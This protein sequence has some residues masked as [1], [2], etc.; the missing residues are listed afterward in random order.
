MTARKDRGLAGQQGGRGKTARTGHAGDA[1]TGGARG[2]FVGHIRRGGTRRRGARQLSVLGAI[3]L[4]LT[5][6]ALL[7]VGDVVSVAQALGNESAALP[8][9]SAPEGDATTLLDAFRERET[10]LESREAAVAEREQALA[11]AAAEIEERLADLEESRESLAQMIALAD[12]AASDD[13]ARLTA[14]YENMRPQEAATLFEDMDPAFSAGFLGMMDPVAAA[15]IMG[16]L[17]PETAYS[18]SAVLAGRNTS[19]PDS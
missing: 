14:V 11:L 5:T 10:R 2:A 8:A 9:G 15:A 18:I 4:L 1:K 6:S 16:R 12:S 17:T 19:A 3:A 7:R 13:L